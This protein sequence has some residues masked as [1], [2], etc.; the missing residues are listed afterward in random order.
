MNKVLTETL[1]AIRI[2]ASMSEV[3]FLRSHG[4]ALYVRFV[5]HSSELCQAK[6]EEVTLHSLRRFFQLVL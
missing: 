5:V 1:K 6:L 2:S 4:G 3:V